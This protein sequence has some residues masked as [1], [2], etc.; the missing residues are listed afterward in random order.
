MGGVPYIT[1]PMPEWLEI[2]VSRRL[3]TRKGACELCDWAYHEEAAYLG[4]VEQSVYYKAIEGDTSEAVREL[5]GILRALTVDAYKRGATSWGDEQKVI[6]CKTFEKRLLLDV[7]A[8][9]ISRA[10][11]GLPSLI[12]N[13]G[14]PQTDAELLQ[15][16]LERYR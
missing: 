15:R 9:L 1:R 10:S 12:E 13:S 2:A 14:Q 7:R 8:T 3:I 4:M 6:W 5:A 11:E 16:V